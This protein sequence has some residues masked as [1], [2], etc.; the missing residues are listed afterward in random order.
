[1]PDRYSRFVE[2]RSVEVGFKSKSHAVWVE[3]VKSSRSQSALRSAACGAR[4]I[5]QVKKKGHK[6]YL[7]PF[8]PKDTEACQQCLRSIN[9]RLT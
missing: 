5:P 7:K 1:M 2:G 8:N 3:E 4:V 6:R 9:S